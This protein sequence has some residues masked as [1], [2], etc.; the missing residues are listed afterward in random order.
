MIFSVINTSNYDLLLGLDFLMKIR[1]IVDV[2]KGVI[3]VWK[4]PGVAIEILPL[5]V[6]NMLQRIA[7]LEEVEHAEMSRDF[8]RMSLEQ[9]CTIEGSS[10]DFASIVIDFANCVNDYL[11]KEDLSESKEIVDDNIDKILPM[12]E[13]IIENLNNHGMN[14]VV[15]DETLMQMFNLVLQEQ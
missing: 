11:F 14:Q 12:E 9:L 1:T 5:N 2:E 7:M 8:S 6:I 3:Q 13:I 15:D 4:G 10:W